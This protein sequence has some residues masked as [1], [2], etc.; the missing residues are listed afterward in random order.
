MML[1]LNSVTN[2]NGHIRSFWN[3]EL[4]IAIIFII[5]YI[6]IYIYICFFIYLFLFISDVL[7]WL[8]FSLYLAPLPFYQ[9]IAVGALSGKAVAKISSQKIIL[10][11]AKE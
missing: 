1:C 3:N 6:F 9:K 10:N 5:Q 8:S 2:A 4:L 7:S 11:N